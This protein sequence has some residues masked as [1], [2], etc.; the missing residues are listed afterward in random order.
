MSDY[1]P[2]A[3]SAASP[4]PEPRFSPPAARAPLGQGIDWKRYQAALVRYRWLILLVTVLGSA[5]AVSVARDLRPQYVAQAT[6][7]I[8]GTDRNAADQGPI[9]SGELLRSYAWIELLKSYAVLDPVVLERRLFLYPANA[10]DSVA[11]AT[12]RPTPALR[13]GQYRATAS[14]SGTEL[15][16]STPDGP[17]LQRVAMG[18]P[19]GAPVG[20]DW[21]PPAGSIAPG[22]TV[23]FSVRSPRDVARELGE[24]LQAQMAENGT[25]LRISLGGG[26]PRRIAAT[27]HALTTR[28]V[29]VA[30]SLKRARLV[31]LTQTLGEQRETAE[32]SLRAA[33]RDLES[34]RTGTVTLPA[35]PA[36]ATT[37]GAG[38]GDP[39]FGRYFSLQVEREQIHDERA[40]IT[41][42][43]QQVR[44]GTG[45]PDALA[46]VAAVRSSPELSQLLT[47]HTAKRAELR[48]LEQRYTA[49]HPPVQRLKEQIKALEENSIPRMAGEI[50]TR[51][52]ARESELASRIGRQTGELR[53]IPS[54][55]IEGA[56]LQRRVEVAAELYTMLRQ[57]HDEA[58]L[59]AASIQ[60]DLRLLD[61]AAVPST[62]LGDRRSFMIVLGVLGSLG[63]SL[64]G[65]ILLDRMDRRVRYPHQ[66][67]DQLG[68]AIL[69]ALPNLGKTGGKATPEAAEA[70][71]ELRLGVVNACGPARPLQLTITSP[72]SGD[73]KSTVAARLAQSFAGQGYRTLLIDGDIRRGELHRPLKG[74]RTP[75]LTDLLAGKACLED[76]LQ[77]THVRSLTLLSS[78]TRMLRGPELLGSGNLSRLLARLGGMYEVVL[79]DS[80]PLGAAVDPYILA[81]STVNVLLVLRTGHT[82]QE[83][84]DAKLEALERLP[85]AIV[86]TVLNDVPRT[87]VYRHYSYEPGYLVDDEIA[88]ER[89]T[90]LQL[91]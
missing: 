60:P 83:L 3:P 24:G 9:R 35:G 8:E 7:W 56:R 71:R 64:F 58:R 86:G 70:M 36:A 12:L 1:L 82:D 34:F 23:E 65:A 5:G 61:A 13:A 41:R 40:A 22:Q 30:A 57:R 11:L 55:E 17:E 91:G 84:A 19:I 76:V 32:A 68:L 89:G 45:S 20:I 4:A 80:P 21:V 14:A 18:Q 46:S 51:L 62:P 81:S 54:R 15:S 87:S 90:Q 10:A 72:Q 6:I 43:I 59:A 78:G 52:G 16:L 69:G 28:Y 53:Q 2:V 33:E 66:V 73:G 25:F 74:R 42:I 38:A 31:S 88:P 63:A 26:D 39:V 27:L 77:P 49:E 50:A 67:T 37:A 75:G 48:A 29:E 85:V 79:I 44:N 47:E